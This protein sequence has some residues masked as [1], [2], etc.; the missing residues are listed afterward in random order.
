[1]HATNGPFAQWQ[2]DETDYPRSGSARQQL[3]FLLGYAIL[4]PSGHNTQPWRFR[5][6]AD[7]VEL[8]ADRTRGLAV[9]DPFDRELLL[10][11]G[12]ALG[13]LQTAIRY[14]G[15]EP[16]TT[17]FPAS[18]DPDLL[19][20]VAIGRPVCPPAEEVER[21]HAIATRRTTRLTFPDEALP[22]GLTTRL[23]SAAE[24]HGCELAIVEDALRKLVIAGLVADG[25]RAQFADPAFRREL[26]SWVHSRRSATRDG[27]S[28]AAFGMPDV[29]SAVGGLV[30]RTF[31]LGDGRA[32]TDEALATGAPA[33]L[34]LGTPNDRPADWLNAGMA[35]SRI[36]LD[37]A[38][39]GWTTAYLN[40][41]IETPALRPQLREAAR[42]AGHPQLL[43]RIGSAEPVEPAVRRPV[44]DV[45]LADDGKSH[46]GARARK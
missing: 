17:V 13:H 30:I 23:R 38:A 9:V 46:G 11:C 34:V 7:G 32:A 25:D 43:L 45:L 31:D 33:L 29:L 19:A 14:F 27:M 6:Q 37:I 2:I 35:L 36:L 12:A 15:H 1:M 24:A 26:A 44:E 28:G 18:A 16:V 39:T 42:I 40:Q 20:R 21:F 22:E 5:L 8:L 41:P 10:S 3:R 4:A